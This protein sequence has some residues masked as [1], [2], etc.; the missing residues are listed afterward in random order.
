MRQLIQLFGAVCLTAG[1]VLFFTQPAGPAGADQVK[2][3]HEENRLLKDQ[4]KTAKT[5]LADAQKATYS[6]NAQD[7]G[8]T[9][10]TDGG[11]DADEK[12][13]P[14]TVTKMILTLSRG[15]TSKDASDS[16]ERSGIIKSSSEFERYLNDQGLSGK[17]QIG[18]HEV[19]S[20]MDFG[21][22]AKELTTVKQ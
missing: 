17:I 12:A 4:L 13:E 7:A 2:A 15:D 16:L 14:E 9:G 6:E 3:L 19:D 11:K 18:Q 22:L 21:R 10:Q 1:A 8:K 20:S 5:A